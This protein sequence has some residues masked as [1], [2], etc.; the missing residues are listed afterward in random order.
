[1]AATV[2]LSWQADI[3]TRVGRNFLR[4]V[5]GDVCAA[6][7]A[8]TTVEEAYRELEV[9][10]DTQG[11]PG[12][13]PIVD[14]IFAKIDAAAVFVADMT[15]VASTANGK[16]S[17][18]PNVLIEYGWAL[19][20]LEH[21]RIVCVMN[22]AYG[23]PSDEALPFDLRH[24]R[25]PITYCLAES[26]TP[27]AKAKE[28][29][30]LTKE[31]TVAIR[32]SL[33]T[34][35]AGLAV[36]QK[37]PLTVL[38]E[39]ASDAGWC[40]DVQAATVGDNDWWSF[41]KRLRQA[42][43]DGDI[44]FWGKKY[45]Y[46][47]GEDLDDEPL[48]KIPPEHFEEF[49]FDPARLAQVDNYDIFTGKLGEPPSANRG[50]IF[51]DLHVD[52]QQAQAWLKAAG[53]APPGAE[54]AVSLSTREE[55]F[56]DYRSVCSLVI[57]S[58]AAK[59]FDRCFVEMIEFSGIAPDGMPMPLQLRTGVQ[60]RAG[61]RGHFSLA[62]GQEVVVPLAFCPERRNE[63]FFFDES[64][65]AYFIPANPTKMILRIY[66][67]GAPGNAL[68]FIDVDAG[69]KAF[70]SIKTVPSDFRLQDDKQRSIYPMPEPVPPL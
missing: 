9:D 8:D 68:V 36:S 32:A 19:K 6:V 51:R 42:A 58:I 55:P 10:S 15:L 21:P 47:F 12:H 49:G 18:N 45:V 70:P 67:G 43:V 31:L 4:D 37:V 40:A 25:W 62:S 17:P 46:E 52:A 53:A 23:H 34:V 30:Q 44:T 11:V 16:R 57:K 20:G 63:W 26:V 60:I 27:E 33:R 56:D 22:T 41:A 35:P 28:K 39:W 48:V 50:R 29:K 3:P 66:G 13:P 5:L 65:K 7:A 54:L 2:F 59:E 14:T 64:G 69:W 1:M 61:E 38:R 24:L